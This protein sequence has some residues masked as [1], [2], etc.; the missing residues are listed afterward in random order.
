MMCQVGVCNNKEERLELKRIFTQ[1][2]NLTEN[3][4]LK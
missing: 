4:E 2:N 1:F 3:C